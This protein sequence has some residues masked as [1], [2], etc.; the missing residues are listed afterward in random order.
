MLAIKWKSTLL[1]ENMFYN[2]PTSAILIIML[3]NLYFS[4]DALQG[5]KQFRRNFAYTNLGIM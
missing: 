2:P 4:N 1:S 5:I 3:R